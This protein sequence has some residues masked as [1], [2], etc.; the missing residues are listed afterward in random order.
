MTI[1]RLSTMNR[2]ELVRRLRAGESRNAI[3]RALR[4][5]PNTVSAY[6]HWA[7]AQGLLTDDLPDLSHLEQLRQTTFRPERAV[8]HPNQSSI[9]GHR[10]AVSDWLAQGLGPRLI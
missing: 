6:R 7:E 2:Q 1:W 9:E 5:S 4:L 8:R 10:Q 3:S